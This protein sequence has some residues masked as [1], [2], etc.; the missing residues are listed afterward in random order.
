MIVVAPKGPFDV[1]LEPLVQVE[2]TRIG[3]KDVVVVSGEI[4]LS[5]AGQLQAA[6]A[7]FSGNELYADLRGVLFIDSAGL[8]VLIKEQGRLAETGGELRLVVKDQSPV[9]RLL[10]LTGVVQSFSVAD[11]L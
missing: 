2:V 7:Q 11:S 5:T 1:V 4:D 9:L 6:L 8:A 3:A 10:E